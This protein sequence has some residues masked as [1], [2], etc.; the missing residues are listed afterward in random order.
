MLSFTTTL[1]NEYKYEYIGIVRL[2]NLPE[3]K[4]LIMM[5]PGFEPTYFTEDSPCQ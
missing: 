5:E 3:G 4:H 1:Q 2:N